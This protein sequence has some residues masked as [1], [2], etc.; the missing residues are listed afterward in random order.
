MRFFLNS[1]YFQV[2]GGKAEAPPSNPIYVHPESPNFGAHWMKEPIS[3]AKVKLTNKSNGTG[4]IMLNSLHKYEPRI[5]L[6]R[7]NSEHR[8][9]IPYPYPETQFIA[10]TA[11]QNEEVTSLKIKY[12]PFAKAF[13]DAKE[14]PDAIYSRDASNYGWFLPP[15]ASYASSSPTPSAPANHRR[16]MEI[17]TENQAPS[18]PPPLPP[19]SSTSSHHQQ[20]QQ[21]A[22]LSSQSQ[23]ETTTSCDRYGS[24]VATTLRTTSARSAPYTTHR[25]RAIS[26]NNSLSPPSSSSAGYL[27][28]DPVPSSIYANY[29]NW[30]NSS[31]S[32]WSTATPGSPISKY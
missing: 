12:N 28:L 10:V 4:Q 21:S 23:H 31:G 14:R 3:F 19:P 17:K 24:V 16:P 13:L 30:Q 18:L 15:S 9:V 2:A 7:V 6:V 5:L 11:Y 1:G 20:Q 29:P 32:Y 27:S 22:S 25:P 8:H 26:S